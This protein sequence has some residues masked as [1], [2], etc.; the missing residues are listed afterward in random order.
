MKKINLLV[1]VALCSL[2]SFAQVYVGGSIGVRKSSE[3]ML[4]IEYKVSTWTV[5]VAPE[6]G[7]RFNDKVQ[8]G[9]QL[10]YGNIASESSP[11]TTTQCVQTYTI[12][13]YFRFRM[14]QFGRF[15]LMG[16]TQ[17]MLSRVKG[18]SST[19]YYIDGWI[20]SVNTNTNTTYHQQGLA[21]F[22][23]LMFRA[24]QHVVLF[25]NVNFFQI[26]WN[27]TSGED[28]SSHSFQFGFNGN[29]TASVGLIYQF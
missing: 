22:P 6:I 16:T 28:E 1:C 20:N 17:A 29:T 11:N 21:F 23:T 27:H 25:S 19:S 7:Y 15:D 9:L 12:A 18:D 5:N 4:D 10:G 8:A 14:A 26:G 24:S 13:P 3:S 2:S